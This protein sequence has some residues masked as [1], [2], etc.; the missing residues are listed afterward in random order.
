MSERFDGSAVGAAGNSSLTST[1]QIMGELGSGGGGIVYKAWH[2][3]LR[4]PV[5]IKELHQG[6]GMNVN[7]QRNEVEALKGM[8]NPY[9]P[10]VFD[11]IVEDGKAYTVIE[12]IEGESLDKLLARGR[13]FTQK[14]IFLWYKQLLSALQALHNEG[15]CHRDIKPANIMLTPK[16]NVCLID[17]NASLVS[18]NDIRL[19]SR[20]LGYASPEQFEIYERYRAAAGKNTSVNAA[21]IDWSRSDIYSLGAT[22]YHLLCGRP[23]AARASERIP[24]ERMGSWW[25]G[26]V[27]VVERSMRIVPADRFPSVDI[28][29]QIL[30]N[31]QKYDKRRIAA[32]RKIYLASALFLVFFVIFAA[33]TFW[34]YRVLDFESDE[35]YS[36][37]VERIARSDDPGDLYMKALEISDSRLDAHYAVAKRYWE[38]GSF[39]LCASHI[40]KQMD[41]LSRFKSHKVGYLYYYLADCYFHMG[42]Y[43]QAAEYF[44]HAVER[45]NDDATMY[46][47]YAVTCMRTQESDPDLIR[48][49]TERAEELGMEQDSRWYLDAEK[50][51]FEGDATSASQMFYMVI[52]YSL[53]R[54]LLVKAYLGRADLAA[55]GE[56]KNI[57]KATDL[58][59]QGIARLTFD[60]KG[61]LYGDG[62]TALMWERLVDLHISERQY[63]QAAKIMG[64]M[65]S[66]YEKS[67]SEDFSRMAKKLAMVYQK[68]GDYE[69]AQRV[70]SELFM[71]DDE[72]YRIPLL[73]AFYEEERQSS[74]PERMRDYSEFERYYRLTEKLYTKH[75]LEGDFAEDPAVKRLR[76]LAETLL[77]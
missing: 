24:L 65:K 40:S 31:I 22:I 67:G 46:R 59:K 68:S 19:V 49:L 4:I 56:R 17:F 54:S 57:D 61:D 60:Y 70:L 30:M 2:T 77:K 76:E 36:N 14:Q 37:L 1:Y 69:G 62:R 73:Q 34:G 29:S 58:L 75:R 64:E 71:K 63:A 53:D 55:R 50:K 8:K 15:I 51:A 26:L 66:Y 13:R 44:A 20:S 6:T 43:E 12:Y 10:Q 74:Q 35:S 25:D 11:F 39:D 38:I 5:V 32:D 28:L 18:G 23:P 45:V 27:Y 52:S 42:E 21:G 16:G 9:L 47:D 3:R 41:R 72:N 7:A 48:D 33:L